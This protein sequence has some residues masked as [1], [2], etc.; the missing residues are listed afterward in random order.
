MKPK[1]L[2]LKELTDN[3]FNAVVNFY[4]HARGDFKDVLRQEI[5]QRI[6]S[7]CEFYLRYKDEPDLLIK[8]HPKYKKELNEIIKIF[9]KEFS[10]AIEFLSLDKIEIREHFLPIYND[11]LFKLTFGL[12]EG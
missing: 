9:N 8:E 3:I 1:P 7:A 12:K 6:K 2:D 10:I 5:I 11:W 4:G